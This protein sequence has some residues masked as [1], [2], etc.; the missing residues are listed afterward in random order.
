MFGRSDCNKMGALWAIVQGLFAAVAPR[1]SVALGRRMLSMSFEN[2][3]QLEPRASYLR[4]VRAMGIG[5]A[6]AGIAGFVMETVA[7]D[8]AAPDGGAAGEVAESTDSA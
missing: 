3:E 8:D 7:E 4:Q 5:L 6:A 2:T 1:R